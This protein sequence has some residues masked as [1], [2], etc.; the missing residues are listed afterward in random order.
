MF[1][2]EKAVSSKAG[3]GG[4][5]TNIV[6]RFGRDSEKAIPKPSVIH[7]RSPPE[8]W[9]AGDSRKVSICVYVNTYMY[10][11]IIPISYLGHH[12]EIM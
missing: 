4:R 8:V 2:V 7:A 1:R 6:P 3:A 12:A 5:E 10:I 9:A 11:P